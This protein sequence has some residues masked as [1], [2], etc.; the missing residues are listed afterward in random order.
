MIEQINQYLD[1]FQ[2]LNIKME[3]SEE[4]VPPL[5]KSYLKAGAKVCGAPALD[6]KFRCVDFLPI[7]DVELLSTS[8]ERY[9]VRDD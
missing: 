9:R 7:L 4:L 5:L 8:F 6:R 2:R 3:K 1:T